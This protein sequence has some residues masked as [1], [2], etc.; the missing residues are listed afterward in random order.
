MTIESIAKAAA[1]ASRSAE[2]AAVDA[3]ALKSAMLAARR[4]GVSLTAVA[5]AA[6]VSR[7]TAMK[8]I[9]QAGQ[10]GKLVESI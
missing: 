2:A 8:W 6:G 7:P 9:D 10:S 3:A 5:K 1:N 4:A